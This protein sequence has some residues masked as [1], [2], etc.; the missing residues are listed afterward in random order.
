[1]CLYAAT[2]AWL[3]LPSDVEGENNAERYGDLRPDVPH[4]WGHMPSFLAELG[5]VERGF[6]G[7]EPL[8]FSEM[9]SWSRLTRMALEPVEAMMLR[10]MSEAYVRVAIDKPLDCPTGSVEVQER[11][12][13]AGVA[14]WRALS[15]RAS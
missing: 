13:S 8:T 15:T 4:D 9:E 7:P 12:S 14:T 3:A 6:N 5:T 11:Q 1:M 10:A 2:S